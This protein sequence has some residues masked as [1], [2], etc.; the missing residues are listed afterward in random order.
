VTGFSADWLRLRE[1]Y[2]IRARSD[3]FARSLR[4]QLPLRPLRAMDLGTGTAANIRY[5]A[6]R[7]GGEQSWL[8][9]DNDVALIAEQPAQLHGSDYICTLTSLQT[10]LATQLHALPLAGCNLV[11]ASA[12]LDLV[13]ASWLDRLAGHCAA[14]GACVLFALSYDGRMECSPGDPDD[15]WLNTL[16]N[17]HQQGDKGFGQALGPNATSH[18]CKA[19]A[20]LDYS[21]HTAASDWAIDAASGPQGLQLQSELID[22]WV[23]AACEI[24][25]EDKFRVMEWGRRRKAH[26]LAGRSHIRVGHQDFT[27][28]PG[29]LSGS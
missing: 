1:P 25:A 4:L 14:A 8:C 5:L 24:A 26:V 2:D 23:A 16:I 20:A 22:G 13:S 17:R 15:A 21:V 3:E 12:L 11:T 29:S 9:V 19:F 10:D 28:W 7:L 27:A 18:A 6:P